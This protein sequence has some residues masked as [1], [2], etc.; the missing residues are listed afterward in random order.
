[1]SREASGAV[2]W[3]VGAGFFRAKE[4]IL[5]TREGRKGEASSHPRVLPSRDLQKDNRRLQR[6]QAKR[7]LRSPQKYSTNTQ[8]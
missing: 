7:L 6:R 3:V 2:A 4:E 8:K 1:M 5:R